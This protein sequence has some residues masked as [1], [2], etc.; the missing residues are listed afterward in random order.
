MKKLK[1]SKIVTERKKAV[2]L[3]K[4]QKRQLKVLC[5]LREDRAKGAPPPK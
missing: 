1:D 2:D 5:S 3:H 4:E